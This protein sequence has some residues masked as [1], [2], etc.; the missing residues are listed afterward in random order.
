MVELIPR[1]A[2]LGRRR[3]FDVGEAG[4]HLF[5]LDAQMIAALDQ[6]AFGIGEPTIG[7]LGG[8]S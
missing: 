3:G 8:L 5:E 1:R 7:A 4:A 6:G 2:L